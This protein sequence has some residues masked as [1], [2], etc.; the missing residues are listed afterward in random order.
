MRNLE[1]CNGYGIRSRVRTVFYCVP[2]PPSLPGSNAEA[3]TTNHEAPQPVRADVDLASLSRAERAACLV[4]NASQH[5]IKLE[6]ALR[7][8]PAGWLAAD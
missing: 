8:V 7:A 4:V 1:V 3:Q 6:N 2:L 5:T